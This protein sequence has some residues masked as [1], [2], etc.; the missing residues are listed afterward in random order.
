IYDVSGRRVVVLLSKE[1]NQGRYDVAWFGQT[2]TGAV[3]ASGVY[4][5]KLR[6]GNV[7]ETRK[8]VLLR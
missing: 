7:V 2:S 4:F 6:A 1:M 5:C 8:M 3:A